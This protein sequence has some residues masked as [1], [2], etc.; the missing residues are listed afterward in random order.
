[1]QWLEERVFCSVL[2]A[3]LGAFSHGM[4]HDPK[5]IYLF[6]LATAEGGGLIS[7][8]THPRKVGRH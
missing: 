3:Q 5:E 1:M 6:V 4:T 7:P 2:Q 8:C